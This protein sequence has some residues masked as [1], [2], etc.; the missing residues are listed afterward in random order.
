M[1][2]DVLTLWEQ[3]DKLAHPYLAAIET[4]KDYQEALVFLEKVWDKVADDPS[5]PYGSLLRILSENIVAYENTRH[6]IADASPAQV[7]TYLMQERG[8]TQKDLEEATG[9]Y[10]SNLSEIL[11]A[12]RNLTTEQ[13]KRL[14]SY[15]KVNPAVFL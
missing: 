1:V 10:Q 7:L 2:K 9:I 5:S 12:K 13:V 4:E 15:F 14:A 11:S 8:L 3:L 6:D